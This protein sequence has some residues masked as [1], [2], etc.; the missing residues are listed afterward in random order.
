MENFEQARRLVRL[1]AVGGVWGNGGGLRF[2]VNSVLKEGVLFWWNKSAALWRGGVLL[3]LG[4]GF[5]TVG[6][7]GD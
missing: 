6:R 4:V 3:V 5:F 7:R 1:C 2:L